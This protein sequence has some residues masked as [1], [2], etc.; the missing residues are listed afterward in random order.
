M[1]KY[2]LKASLT[3]EG[4]AGLLKEGGTGRREAITKLVE[5]MGGTL[6]SLYFAFGDTDV[7]VIA[8]APEPASVVAASLTVSSTGI[9]GIST[10][11]LLT[12]ED[13]DAARDTAGQIEYRPPGQ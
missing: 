1:P 3:Q 8:D 7:Y 12:P 9:G 11:V 5:S 4:A 13:L 6:E 2:M 10:T